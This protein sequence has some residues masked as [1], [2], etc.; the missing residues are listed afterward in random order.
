[1]QYLQKSFTLPTS[2]G[3]SQLKW[4]LAFMSP[5]EFQEHYKLT[6]LEYANMTFDWGLK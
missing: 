1:M 4:D 3:V 6:D 2:N 5:K